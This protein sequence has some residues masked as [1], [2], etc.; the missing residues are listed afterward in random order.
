MLPIELKLLDRLSVVNLRNN[1]FREIPKV[2]TSIPQLREIYLS[3]N[4]KLDPMKALDILSEVKK[5]DFLY[6]SGLNITSIPSGI[7][8]LKL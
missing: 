1:D 5:L 6:L 2:L 8:D 3:G 7:K 4:T